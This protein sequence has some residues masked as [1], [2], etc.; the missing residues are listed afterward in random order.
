MTTKSAF[1]ALGAPMPPASMHRSPHVEELALL[2]SVETDNIG[3]NRVVIRWM[4]VKLDPTHQMPGLN[5]RTRGLGS[6]RPVGQV[7]RRGSTDQ[8]GTAF[9]SLPGE[10]EV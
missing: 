10:A 8:A 3:L 7:T 6:L 2:E 9:Q 1:S 5:I 4:S